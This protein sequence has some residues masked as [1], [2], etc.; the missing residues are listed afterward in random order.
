[1]KF[2]HIYNGKFHALCSIT[3]YSQTWRFI[4]T[5]KC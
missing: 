4:S 5:I 3:I 2:I 1:L